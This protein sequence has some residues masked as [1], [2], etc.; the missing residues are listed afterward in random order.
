MSDNSNTHLLIDACLQLF[1]LD[2][3][4]Q[5]QMPNGISFLAKLAPKILA[6]ATNSYGS[7]RSRRKQQHSRLILQYLDLALQAPAIILA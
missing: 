4:L 7:R 5:H 1:D 3:L 6:A 2:F